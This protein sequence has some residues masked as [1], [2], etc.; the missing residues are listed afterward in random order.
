MFMRK[1]GKAS[2]FSL[3]DKTGL[4]QVYIKLDDVGE[5][6][7]SIFKAGDVGD[8]VGVEG[9]VMLTQT[10]EITIK[11]EKYTHL[12]KSLKPLPEKFHGLSD[13][14][15][16]YRKRY[17]DLIMNDESLKTALAR[18]QIIKAMRE[19]FGSLG[20]T[21]VETPILEVHKGGASARP[22]I[23]HHNA[24]DM[25][26]Y[27]RIAL[28][29][30]LK[31]LLVGGMERVF[32]I[33]RVFR[34]EGVD[35]KHNPEFTM[36]ELYQAY[37]NLDS[38][39][40][41]TE[42]VFKYIAK[43]VFGKY[44]FKM[45]ETEIDLEKP[46]RKVNMTDMIKEKTGIDFKANNYTLEEATKLAKENGIKV[47]P[48]FTVGHIIN[49]FF[50]KF[51]E[52]DL[53]QPTFLCGHPIEIS[54]LTKENKEDPRFV[55]RFELYINGC[56]FGNAYTELNNPIEQLK[57][58]EEEL[59]ER[60]LGNDEAADI[61]ETFLDAM[62]YGMPPAGGVGIGIDRLVMFFLEQDSIRDVLLFP[63]MKIIE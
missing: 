63:T 15:E 57:R 61:D 8:I 48:H 45:G 2:F 49:E 33:G 4:I 21:E 23:T 6:D 26:L 1:M 28:E 40:E 56:E 5:L 54:P 17:L 51:C 52:E 62:E 20:F 50:E 53:I 25:S 30:S 16:R 60:Q 11:C 59:R 29:I 47:E 43:N 58:F 10:G 14:E 41:I 9:Y 31:K 12:A 22:F 44:V 24:L 55:E 34:N 38:M 32:E 27:L 35:T 37:G 39:M 3:K 13:V 18:P 36:V 19:Y 42:G 46:F 7:Y